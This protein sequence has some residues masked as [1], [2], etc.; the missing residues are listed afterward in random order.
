VFSVKGIVG[1]DET[2]GRPLGLPVD[3]LPVADKVEC[4]D[5]AIVFDFLAPLFANIFFSDAHWED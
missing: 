3:Q 2:C 4:G 5:L 1:G